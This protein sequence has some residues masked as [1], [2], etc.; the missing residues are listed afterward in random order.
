M[1]VSKSISETGVV[2]MPVFVYVASQAIVTKSCQRVK[3]S[4]SN[5]P[6]WYAHK[7]KSRYTS[8]QLTTFTYISLAGMS[9]VIIHVIPLAAH[10]RAVSQ[11]RRASLVYIIIILL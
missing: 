9:N 3:L 6:S 2:E 8:Y 7:G 11:R 4:Y 5:A 10:V 1:A